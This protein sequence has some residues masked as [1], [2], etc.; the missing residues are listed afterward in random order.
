MGSP[1]GTM[2]NC[3]DKSEGGVVSVRTW[4]RRLQR[5]AIQARFFTYRWRLFA[6]A[7]RFLPQ[8]H[9]RVLDIGAER[10]PFRPYLPAETAYIALDVVPTSGLHVVSSALALPFGDGIFDGVICTEVLEHVPEPELALREIFRVLRPG[11]LAYITVPMTWGL[12][13]VPHDYYRFT[14][15]GIVH[16]LDK[17][18]LEV[19]QVVQIGG[20]F[21]TGLARLEDVG[22]L[23]VFRLCFPLKFL[24]GNKGRLVLASLLVLPLFLVLDVVAGILDR[25]V[26]YARADALGWSVLARKV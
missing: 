15:Y 18:G 24:M 9:G 16:L 2:L 1:W 22:G 25:V 3:F 12:H 10:Q 17:A 13:Y 20:L 11:G 7:E 19:V 4:L 21:T 5:L 6:N 26:P 23:L 14:R 8:F